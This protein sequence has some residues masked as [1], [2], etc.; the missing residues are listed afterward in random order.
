MN[1]K[2][3]HAH[4]TKNVLYTLPP[5]TAQKTAH[6]QPHT[7]KHTLKSLFIYACPAAANHF[8]NFFTKWRFLFSLCHII[9]IFYLTRLR[10]KAPSSFTH[11]ALSAVSHY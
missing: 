6:T 3:L 7:Q 8:A 10:L 1:T 5:F 11:L 9:I 4:F 2:H